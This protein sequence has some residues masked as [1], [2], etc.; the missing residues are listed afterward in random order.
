MAGPLQPANLFTSASGTV[1]VNGGTYQWNGSGSTQNVHLGTGANT[2]FQF[3]TDFGGTISGFNSGEFIS[4][5]GAATAVIGTNQITFN[6]AGGGSKTITLSTPGVTYDASNLTVFGGNGIQTSVTEAQTNQPPAATAA[7]VTGVSSSTANNSYKAGAEIAITVTFNK[8][9]TVTGTPTLTLETGTTDRA[10]N[11]TSG[12]GT[13]VL[14]F[15]YTVQP[16]DTSSDLD[17]LAANALA[18]A[19]GSIKNDGTVNANLTLAAPG[20]AGSLGA[21]KNIVIDTLAPG[22]PTVVLSAASDSGTANNDGITNVLKPAITGTAEAGSTVTLYDTGGVAV[23]GSAVA[24]G[25]NWSITPLNNLTEGA[26]TLT[27]KATDA[28]GNIG[29]ASTGLAVTIDTV[30]PTLAITSNVTTLKIGETAAITFTFSEDPGAT[31]AAGDVAVSGGSLGAITG[32]G[33]T[34]TATFTP[35]AATN[36]G[37]ASISVQA[38][39]YTDAAGNNGGAGAPRALT[40]DT[41]A[42]GAPTVVLSA[43]SDSGTA[44]ND[45]ITNVLKPVITGTAE[46]GSTVTLYDT[47]G[48]AVLGSAVATGGNWSIT[49]VN[50]LTEGAHTLTAKATDAAGN[51]GAAS[52]GLA[53]TI[54]TVKPTLAITSNVT[55][56]K[57]GETAAITFTFSE[58]PGATFAAGDVAVSGGSLGAITGS[59]L[60]RTATFTPTAATNNGTASISVQADL[61]TDAAG[62]NGGAG[63]PRALT[64]DT[65]APGAPTVVLSAA[66]DSGTANNDGIT[67]V[68]KPV[69]TGTAEAGS[70][71]TLYD[72]VAVLGSA[73]ATGGNWSITPVNNL[74]EGAHTLTAKATDAAGNIGAASTGLAVTIDTVSPS[75]NIVFGTNKLGFAGTSSVDITF[76]ETVVQFG[77]EDL[78]ATGGFLSNFQAIDGSTYKATFN[79]TTGFVGVGSVKIASTYSDVAGNTGSERQAGELI[80]NATA[81]P[82]GGGGGGGGGTPNP[83]TPTPNPTDANDYNG[84][85]PALIV[86]N[87]VN[88]GTPATAA[89]LADLAAFAKLQYVAYQNQGVADPGLGPYEALGRGFAETAAFQTKYGAQSESVFIST[90]YKAVFGFDATVSQQKHFQDQIDYFEMI[91]VK[92][93][94]SESQAE[95]LAKGAVLGQMLGVATL[96]GPSTHPYLLEATNFLIDASDGVVSYGKPL[97]F[98]DVL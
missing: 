65:L 66:S 19:G 56:L 62:N 44:N 98:W 26:H 58:D 24:T 43:A 91:Y 97:T 70:T 10:V 93:N 92:A 61:Y 5:S 52:T 3:S 33:L 84:Q 76:A 71:V 80:I 49:P 27:A 48:V 45:G 40:F 68:L 74:T 95:I 13:S 82:G 2:T 38:D 94:L 12:S 90:S 63:A 20:A 60:T 14:V 57:I 9:V 85:I 4:Y 30:K 59:G 11:Y 18:L 32:S 35:T 77:L 64:F 73:V 22:A 36:N 23:L 37:T 46:A 89:K 21:N 28:A 15:K 81:P 53:V 78:S 55:T 51:I 50:N 96:Q 41:L 16:G 83:T 39:L 88:G 67:N 31:F 87:F 29:A 72:G 47:G 42:P 25:G 8:A 75:P 69:I 1:E 54:D 6:L 7:T 79:A 17:Y 34:R 86:A